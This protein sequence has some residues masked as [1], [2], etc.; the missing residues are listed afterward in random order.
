M[1][2]QK[3]RLLPT[4]G[5]LGH[6]PSSPAGFA[7]E[8]SQRFSMFPSIDSDADLQRALSRLGEI[9]HAEEGTME[10]RERH[11][12]ALL[13]EDYERRFHPIPPPTALQAIAF[14]MDQRGMEF[15]GLVPLGGSLEEVQ[16]VL[17]GKGSLTLEMIVRLHTSLGIPYEC[18]IE[19][20]SPSV[21][22]S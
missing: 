8:L 5:D 19:A 16:E 21:E 18:L 9:F 17:G 4:A 12:L 11:V 7:P 3:I 6:A 13:V 10:G 15:E 20:S 22:A 14:A 2:S 1:K